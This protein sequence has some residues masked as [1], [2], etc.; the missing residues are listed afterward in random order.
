VSKWGYDLQYHDL[1]PIY[2]GLEMGE[3]NGD[4]L[5]RVIDYEPTTQLG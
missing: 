1:S 2:R 3:A 4:L 5:T